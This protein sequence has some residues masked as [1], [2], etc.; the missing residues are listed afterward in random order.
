M[1]RRSNHPL[2]FQRRDLFGSEAEQLRDR[3]S[4]GVASPEGRT[5]SGGNVKIVIHFILKWVFTIG[6][7]GS[8]V[9]MVKTVSRPL[10]TRS[11]VVGRRRF[12][13]T[14]ADNVLDGMGSIW[15][16]VMFLTI[17]VLFWI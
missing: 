12:K 16:F 8:F 4:E 17:A 11:I 7:I 9:N 10:A 2:L 5:H 14:T 6:T 13:K 15:G 1:P 3:R